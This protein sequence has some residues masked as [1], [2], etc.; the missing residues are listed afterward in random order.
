VA[1]RSYSITELE[2][3]FNMPANTILPFLKRNYE[4]IGYP[5]E[6]D[7]KGVKR[8]TPKQVKIIFDLLLE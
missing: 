8:Y 5:Q 4:H 6:I 3:I 2:E 7:K 1:V